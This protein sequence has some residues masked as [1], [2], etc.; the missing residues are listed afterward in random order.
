MAIPIRNYP[1]TD[2]HDLNLDFLLRNWNIF[3]VD[4]EDLKRR[5]KALEDWREV[6]EPDINTL[7]NQMVQVLGDILLLQNRVTTTENNINILADNV[8]NYYITGTNLSQ[9]IHEDSPTGPLID[10]TDP[11]ALTDF[12]NR[13]R[14]PVS[15]KGQKINQVYFFNNTCEVNV[16]SVNQ[17]EF[18]NYI[19]YF[20]DLTI[21]KR[22][23]IVKNDGTTSYSST[24]YGIRG[25]VFQLQ[26]SA[27]SVSPSSDPDYPYQLVVNDFTY[28]QNFVDNY[29][30]DLYFD[31]LDYFKTYSPIICE[32]VKTEEHQFTLYFT[33]IPA[34]TFYL[35]FVITGGV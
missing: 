35:N 1:Y 19:T 3:M 13:F 8:K 6:A 12:L 14:S 2:Y 32:Y 29:Q 5:V 31:T 26:I 23:F 24:S 20:G 15:T 25:Q 4:I 11:V 17:I 33:E 27:A 16:S 9:Q 10:L 21:K 28:G 18:Y 34:G 7:K 22:S 30:V